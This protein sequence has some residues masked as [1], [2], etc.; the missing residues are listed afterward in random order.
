MLLFKFHA[1]NISILNSGIN[2]KV[3][4]YIYIFESQF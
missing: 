1:P 4:R 3:L 2:I